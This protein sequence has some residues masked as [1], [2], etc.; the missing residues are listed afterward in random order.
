MR[1]N[2]VM[3]VTSLLMLQT[4]CIA[5][6]LRDAVRSALDNYEDGVRRSSMSAN[7]IYNLSVAD[8]TGNAYVELCRLV[9]NDVQSVFQGMSSIATNEAERLVLM[10][11][12]WQYD[13]NY[14]LSAYDVIANMAL[15]NEVSRTECDWFGSPKRNDLANCIRCRY[16]ETCVT[17][18]AHKIMIVT[19]NTNW[20]WSVISGES[21]SNYLEEASS[22]LWR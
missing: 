5:T 18:L 15:S 17:N 8:T 16:Q 4:V 14:Y 3:M 22:G 9:S 21:Y 13:E 6:E 12:A 11:T 10:S 20:Y 2:K 19:G 1:C 7:A